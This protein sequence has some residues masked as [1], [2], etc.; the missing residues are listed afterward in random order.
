MNR[1][2]D[3]SFTSDSLGEVLLAFITLSYD[4]IDIC[5]LKIKRG[6]LRCPFAFESSSA[7]RVGDF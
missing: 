1:H 5:F 3:K 2:L 7:F 6:H 4:R